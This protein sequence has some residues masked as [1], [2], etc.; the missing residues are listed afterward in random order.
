MTAIAIRRAKGGAA[1]A[2]AFAALLAAMH[3]WERG[4]RD[5]AML[6]GWTL[7]A[8]VLVLAVY[9]VKKALPFLPLGGSTAWMQVHSWAGFLAVAVF[10]LH[11][12]LRMPTGVLESVLSLAFVLVAGSGVAGLALARMLPPMLRTRG[13]PI[14]YSRIPQIRR[15]LAFRAAQLVAPSRA[16]SEFHRLHL[17]EWLAKPA[18]VAAHLR[19][20]RVPM[21]RRLERI[22][23]LFRYLS[24]EEQAMARSLIDIVKKKDL[25]DVHH[26]GQGALR[27][28]TMIHVPVTGAL[29][30]LAALHALTVLAFRGGS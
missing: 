27:A 18:D 14:L 13:E 24:P 20:S 8:L 2:A 30:I 6:S 7:F 5:P 19:G 11:A 25:L 9:G 15:E 22:E 29:V 10:A 21:Q 23:S 17:V 28:W 16:L 26:A 4:L 3:V 1:A 12:G